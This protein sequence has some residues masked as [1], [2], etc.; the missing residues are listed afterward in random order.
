MPKVR[1]E[2][3]CCCARLLSKDDIVKEM[4][5]SSQVSRIMMQVSAFASQLRVVHISRGCCGV[6]CSCARFA[7]TLPC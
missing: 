4:L 7:T 2:I 3:T 6:H 5:T 1:V